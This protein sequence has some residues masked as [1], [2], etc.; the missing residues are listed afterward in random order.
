MH[1]SSWPELQSLRLAHALKLA[2]DAHA[3]GFAGIVYCSAQQNNMA[4][5]AV[6]G[7]A[8]TS[9]RAAWTEHPVE[10]GSGN[11]HRA[12]AAALEGSKVPLTP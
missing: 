4:C 2:A 8:L 3:Q 9:M 7:D 1:A 6:L 5:Y 12:I 11:L 10:P